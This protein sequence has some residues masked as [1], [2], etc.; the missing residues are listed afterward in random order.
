M[1]AIDDDTPRPPA[2][3]MGKAESDY[4]AARRLLSDRPPILDVAAFHSQ[5]C[6][7]KYLKA[8]LVAHNVL[9]AK[10]HDIRELLNLIGGVNTALAGQLSEADTLT[11]YAIEARYPMGTPGPS[12]ADAREAFDLASKVRDAVRVALGEARLPDAQ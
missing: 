12:P 3:W 10:T 5:Q 4:A 2:E 7:E 6:A 1:T 8:F 11:P 9:F